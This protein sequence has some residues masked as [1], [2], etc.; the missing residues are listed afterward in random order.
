MNVARESGVLG[1]IREWVEDIIRSER[2]NIAGEVS[3]GISVD[4]VFLFYGD[5]DKGSEI[6]KSCSHVMSLEG[7]PANIK[8]IKRIE[9]LENKQKQLISE[10]Q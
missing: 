8:L 9:A 6:Y 5:I 2:V 4:T 7:N 10:S 1:N 3:V